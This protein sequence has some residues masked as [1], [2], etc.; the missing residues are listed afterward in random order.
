MLAVQCRVNGWLV[1]EEPC[2][3]M[4]E[5]WEAI[6]RRRRVLTNA[7]AA[8]VAEDAREYIVARTAEG[9]VAVTFIAGEPH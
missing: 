2:T 4:I 8:I 1:D 6:G 9:W 7:G 5:A 3:T